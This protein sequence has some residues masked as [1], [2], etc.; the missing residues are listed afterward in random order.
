[1]NERNNKIIE[2]NKLIA[3]FMT[4]IP[5]EGTKYGFTT[6]PN[7][8]SAN[9]GDLRRPITWIKETNLFYYSSW[10]WL[11]P[12]CERISN[13]EEVYAFSILPNKSCDVML[14]GE[15]AELYTPREGSMTT[16]D[17]VYSTVI[18]FI[19]WYNENKQREI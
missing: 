18:K 8:F 1:M 14:W 13:M 11:M 10:D 12:V 7:K 4:D 15:L 9:M 16:L 3:E 17:C 6:Y 5:K 19:K 2:E